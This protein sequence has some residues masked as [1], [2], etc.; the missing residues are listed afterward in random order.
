[1]R[2]Y[3]TDLRL[4]VNCAVLLLHCSGSVGFGSQRRINVAEQN[5]HVKVKWRR[6]YAR[7]SDLS[8]I[9]LTNSTTQSLPPRV[10]LPVTLFFVLA[11]G[12]FVGS[13]VFIRHVQV[14]SREM[15]TL[16]YTDPVR[17]TEPFVFADL[18]YI[19]PPPLPAPEP[20]CARVPLPSERFFPGNRTYHEFDD[21][22]LVVFFSHAR[23][24]VNLDYYKEVYSEFFPNVSRSTVY[25]KRILS[26]IGPPSDGV[27]R[28]KEPG[29][30]GI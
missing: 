27:R 2:N 29:R 24:D 15:S 18:A 5:R 23:Y 3:S 6:R 7:L 26:F 10:L 4:W 1:M 20:E 14:E 19:P 30:Q 11:M 22:L 21:I 25:L 8:R 9:C 16:K 12:A 13:Y 17:T 28:S